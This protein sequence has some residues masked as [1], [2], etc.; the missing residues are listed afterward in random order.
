[1]RH[2]LVCQLD[3]PSTAA[4]RR[5]AASGYVSGRIAGLLRLL[6]DSFSLHR[7]HVKNAPV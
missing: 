7:I 5:F 2:H 6:D 3:R 1:M 4:W